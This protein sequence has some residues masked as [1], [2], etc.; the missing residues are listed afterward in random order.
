MTNLE[1]EASAPAPASRAQRPA[2]IPRVHGADEQ[3]AISIDVLRYVRY[4]REDLMARMRR[5]TERAL[6]ERRITL[7]QSRQLL[8]MYEEGL[9][10]YTYLERD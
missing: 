2:P 9:S 5:A 8:R 4:D 3:D 7:E 6:Q 1:P 10:G